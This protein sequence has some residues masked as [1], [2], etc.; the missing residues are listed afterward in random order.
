MSQPSLHAPYPPF[1]P[2][3]ATSRLPLWSLSLGIAAL[4]LSWVPLLGLLLGLAAIVLSAFTLAKPVNKIKPIL[5][6]MLGVVALIVNVIVLAAA[7]F[8]SENHADAAVSV[9]ATT[10]TATEP[11]LEAIAGPTTTTP[12]VAATTRTPP[13]VKPPT[14]APTKAPTSTKAAPTRRV[15]LEEDNAIRSA[16][17]YLRFSAFSR[18]GLIEQL[19]SDAGEGY[20]LKT[21][22][23]AVDSLH[24]NWKEQAYKSAKSYLKMSG[25]SRKG[26]IEQLESD[27]G[28]GFTHSQAVYGVEK[29]G[30]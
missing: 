4:L 28:E 7:G 16:Q 25:F 19:S 23:R 11:T 3:P 10:A 30:L 12:T 21:A 24:V 18:K 13:T 9:S 27:A 6:L 1:A 15:S 29:A 8:A 20:P 5:G 22:T 26:L 2:Q 14:K 17:S